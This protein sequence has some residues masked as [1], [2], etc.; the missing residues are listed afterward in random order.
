MRKI[1]S[2]ANLTIAYIG[3]GGASHT[4]VSAWN[5]LRRESDY[6]KQ[7]FPDL[8][9]QIEDAVDFRGD[10]DDVEDDILERPWFRRAWVLQEVV[11]SQTLMLLSGPYWVSWDDFCKITLL[12]PRVH[13]RYGLRL[14][15]RDLYSYI[16]NQFLCRCMFHEAMGTT[17]RLP[18]WY[19][20]IKSEYDGQASALGILAYSKRLSATDPRDKIFAFLGLD[21]QVAFA[22]FPIDYTREWE[23]VY[24]DFARFYISQLENYDIL[25]YVETHYGRYHNTWVPYW[26]GAPLVSRTILSILPSE[27][28]E[29]QAARK[30]IVRQTHSYEMDNR[31]RLI[32]QGEIV[33]QVTWESM[34]IQ[35]NGA[36]EE[37]FERLRDQYASDEAELNMHILSK[38]EMFGYGTAELK[39]LERESEGFLLTSSREHVMRNIPE[40]A[41]WPHF[42]KYGRIDEA[43]GEE[44][45]VSDSD[46]DQ[47]RDAHTDEKSRLEGS[48]PKGSVVRNREIPLDESLRLPFEEQGIIE[49]QLL[50][51]SRKTVEFSSDDGSKSVDIIIDR[52]SIVDQRCFAKFR[53]ADEDDDTVYV[54]LVPSGTEKN[55]LVVAIAGARIPFIVREVADD[56][57]VREEEYEGLMLGKAPRRHFEFIGECL[58]NDFEVYDCVDDEDQDAVRSSFVVH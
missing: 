53:M 45:S 43:A 44:S 12:S 11:V 15:K 41:T 22:N 17:S 27:N 58:F 34:R 46:S 20:S 6:I 42:A 54:A 23:D 4:R 49:Q 24:L 2:A 56:P 57:S 35:L 52:S 7:N 16:R 37:V 33:G 26:N 21:P 36:M 40:W 31:H 48:K 38:W 28:E 8:H 5:F 39:S 29:Q 1:Y 50:S 32:C 9:R 25:S 51:R 14:E 47:E 18:S 19:G 13:D 3:Y 55:D 30:H 10:L